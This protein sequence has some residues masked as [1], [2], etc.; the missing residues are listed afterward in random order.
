MKVKVDMAKHDWEAAER[1]L[2]ILIRKQHDP[3]I[4]ELLL[5][6]YSK[7]KMIYIDALKNKRWSMDISVAAAVATQIEWF[8]TMAK[9]MSED[10]AEFANGYASNLNRIAYTIRR[11]TPTAQTYVNTHRQIN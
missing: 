4:R 11:Q 8:L 2:W 6:A 1:V 7:D 3:I 5:K 10:I 9:H